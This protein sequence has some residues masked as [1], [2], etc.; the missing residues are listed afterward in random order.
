MIRHRL[1]WWWNA[2]TR[3]AEVLSAFWFWSWAGV[4]FGPGLVF[5]DAEPLFNRPLYK[6][7][8][9]IAPEAAWGI[10]FGIIAFVQSMAMCGGVDR[11]RFPAAI[12]SSVTMTFIALSFFLIAPQLHAPYSYGAV[13]VIML[14]VAVRNPRAG[15][16]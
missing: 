2:D 6:L 3:I 10:W 15:V 5:A 13:A 4:I 14:W 7:M 8:A 16:S 11:W 9:V 12:M 1:F